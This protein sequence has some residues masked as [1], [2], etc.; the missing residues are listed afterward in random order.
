MSQGG[1]WGAPSGYGEKRPAAPGAPGA[2]PPRR[3][4]V[5]K[6]ADRT[7]QSRLIYNNLYGT[8][9]TADLGLNLC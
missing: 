1:R 4:Q 8:Y 6:V 9:G 5:E 3:L 2:S 7:L